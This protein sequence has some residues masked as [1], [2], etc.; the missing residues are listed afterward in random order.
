MLEVES[1]RNAYDW[2]VRGPGVGQAVVK[3]TG[4]APRYSPS[5]R[6][7]AVQKATALDVVALCERLGFDVVI[8]GARAETK[9]STSTTPTSCR[10]G[11]DEHV[12]VEA[13]LW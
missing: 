13:G 10:S 4:R 2:L 5:R 8:T 12:Q 11:E 7:Y 1:A 3:V 6:G 9:V